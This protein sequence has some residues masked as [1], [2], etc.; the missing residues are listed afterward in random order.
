V[1]DGDLDETRQGGGG[2]AENLRRVEGEEAGQEVIEL[3]H[4]VH[5]RDL[6][7]VESRGSRHGVETGGRGTGLSFRIKSDDA[8]TN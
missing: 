7:L 4:A 3:G 8:L 6:R 1:F 5:V 2:N